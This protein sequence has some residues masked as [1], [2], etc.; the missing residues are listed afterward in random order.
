MTQHAFVML[1][2]VPTDDV[3]T[4]SAFTV[5]GNKL[6]QAIPTDCVTATVTNPNPPQIGLPATTS[7]TGERSKFFKNVVV[8]PADINSPQDWINLHVNAKNKNPSDTSKE[9]NGG[10]PWVVGLVIQDC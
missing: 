5:D 4:D 9:N 1:G 10:K 7:T 6:P 8:W 2:S 3:D